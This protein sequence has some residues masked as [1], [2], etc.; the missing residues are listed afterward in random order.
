MSGLQDSALD[1]K[2][3]VVQTLNPRRGWVFLA[4]VDCRPGQGDEVLILVSGLVSPA[5]PKP[6]PL[7]PG[8]EDACGLCGFRH[9]RVRA[10]LPMKQT[11]VASRGL[12]DPNPAKARDD[13]LVGKEFIEQLQ[14]KWLTKRKY[15]AK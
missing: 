9:G 4:K 12:L 14:K 13:R 10:D 7:T 5:I 8:R 2:H 11:L 6:I 1:G 15:G 3:S